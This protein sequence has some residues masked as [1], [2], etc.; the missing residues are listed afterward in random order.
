MVPHLLPLLTDPDTGVRRLVAAALAEAGATA[1]PGLLRLLQDPRPDVRRI[2]AGV[3]GR[4]RDRSAVPAL[5]ACLADPSVDMRAMAITAL[6]QLGDPATAADLADHLTDEAV[7][8]WTNQSLQ[9]LALQ[10]LKQ[11]G[12]E[13]AVSLVERWRSMKTGSPPPMQPTPAQQAKSALMAG[14]AAPARPLPRLADFQR[15]ATHPDWRLRVRVFDWL[16]T[17][18]EAQPAPE[19]VPLLLQGVQDA[20]AN[21]RHAALRA[22]ARYP[23]T[24]PLVAAMQGALLDDEYLVADTAAQLLVKA[25]D[26]AVPGLLEAMQ[27]PA[28]DVRG[29]AME[30]LGRLRAVVAV[31]P[32]EAALDDDRRPSREDKSLGQ[33]AAEALQ[34]INTPRAQAALAQR[35]PARPAA[36]PPAPAPDPQAMILYPGLDTY[37]T[38]PLDHHLTTLLRLVDELHDADWQIRQRAARDLNRY[39]RTLRGIRN[40]RIVERLT[41]LLDD[42]E[43]FVRMSAVEALAWIGDA[44]AVPVLI[45]RLKDHQFTVRIAAVRALAEIGHISALPA[46]A[47]RLDQREEPHDL[48]REV[49]AEVLGRFQ[50]EQ[51]LPAL[52]NA[53]NDTAGFVRRAVVEALGESGSRQAIPWVVQAL[54][55]GDEHIRWTAV[56]ALSR[57]HATEAV[58][59]LARYLS[60]TFKPAWQEQPERRLCDV[61]A[62]VLEQMDTP[63]AR[64]ALMQ[65]RE[66]GA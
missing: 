18:R 8:R 27:H 49:V 31:P 6:G 4:T 15:A 29:R 63:E 34:A 42:D 17:S 33:I 52:V 3:L 19:Y 65:W 40:P 11:L 53:L 38:G 12:T 7:P 21:V 48:V 39:A 28:V 32:L 43:N 47:A 36:L 51:V 37:E 66:V 50:Q 23:L 46:L 61:V 55:Q 59:D 54:H 14:Q 9:A 64:A 22:L 20:E 25:G 41:A 10:S 24:E 13:E 60:D 30:C 5:V 56:E 2:A 44:A 16:A 26:A 62:L 58:P 1:V 45:Q 35:A 57:L